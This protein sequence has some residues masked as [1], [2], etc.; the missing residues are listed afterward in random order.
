MF[1]FSNRKAWNADY[2]YSE[3]FLIDALDRSL[4]SS[5]KNVYFYFLSANEYQKT[6]LLVEKKMF[7]DV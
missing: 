3:Y 5:Q 1:Q 4:D 2:K 6:K 7:F